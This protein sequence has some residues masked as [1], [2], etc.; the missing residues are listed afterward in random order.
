[1]NL[2]KKPSMNKSF[3]PN[4]IEIKAVSKTNNAVSISITYFIF[5]IAWIS[6]SDEFLF[7]IVKDI[8][9]YKQLQLFK[10]LIYMLITTIFIFFLVKNRSSDFKNLS[11]KRNLSLVNGE[12]RNVVCNNDNLALPPEFIL[13]AKELEN[14]IKDEQFTLY[15]QPQVNIMTGKIIGVEALI[16]WYHPV[17]GFIPPIEFIPLAEQTGHIYEIERN[18]V[19]VALIQKQ[20]WE[21]EGLTELKMSINLSTKT[22]T[23][24]ENFHKLENLLEEFEVDYSKIVFEITETAIISDIKS[25]SQRLEGLRKKG[26]SI[27]LDDFGTGFSSLSHLREVPLNIIKLDR[28][29]IDSIKEN[30]R[31]VFI[32]KALISLANDLNYEVIAEGI[33]TNDQITFLLKHN[34]SIGQGYLF[35]KPLPIEQ[36]TDWISPLKISQ[37][38]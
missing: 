7:W 14:A 23:D 30:G 22:L 9:I 20:K 26:L 2:R 32:I 36:L 15:Y 24:E 11:I 31:E 13:T 17:M 37:G 28:T 1:M 34:C 5:G 4:K 35:S 10:G 16:R 18:V 12:S 38:V 27:A 6:L 19:K 33:E 3:S 29:F 21:L 8:E 25:A